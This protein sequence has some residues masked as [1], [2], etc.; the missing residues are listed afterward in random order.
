MKAEK[1]LFECRNLEEKYELVTKEKEVRLKSCIQAPSCPSKLSPV[2]RRTTVPHMVSCTPSLQR[3]L[4]ERDSLRE[5]NEELRCAQ[6]QPRGLTQAG[7]LEAYWPKGLGLGWPKVLLGQ[8]PR[9]CLAWG[10]SQ[11]TLETG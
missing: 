5:A 9:A 2:S 3:L 1:W 8:C 6:L 4:A 11:V 7:E 10:Q